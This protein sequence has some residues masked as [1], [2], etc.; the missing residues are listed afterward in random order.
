[1]NFFTTLSCVKP[2]L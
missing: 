2:V 1:M